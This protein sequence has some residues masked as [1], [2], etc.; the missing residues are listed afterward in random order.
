MAKPKGK[1]NGQDKMAPVIVFHSD[2]LRIC[3]SWGNIVIALP[4]GSVYIHERKS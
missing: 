3:L 2:S 1:T 4:E